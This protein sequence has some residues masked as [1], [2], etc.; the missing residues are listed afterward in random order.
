MIF[1]F[2]KGNFD[3]KPNEKKKKSDYIKIMIINDYNHF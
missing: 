3:L 1:S 2:K